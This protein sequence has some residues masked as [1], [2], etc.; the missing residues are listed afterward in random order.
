METFLL[1]LGLWKERKQYESLMNGYSLIS[2]LNGWK[3]ME[4]KGLTGETSLPNFFSEI[5]GF[6]WT[7]E[8]MA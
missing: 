3:D 8:K 2:E 5:P 7:F 1:S 6:L 4:N